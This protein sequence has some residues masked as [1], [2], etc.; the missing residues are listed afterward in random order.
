MVISFTTLVAGV[1]QNW[2]AKFGSE[3][4]GKMREREKAENEYI[5]FA[6]RACPDAFI[7]FWTRKVRK[8]VSTPQK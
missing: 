2:K 4:K 1:V 7:I 3:L 8:K 6:T 5:V